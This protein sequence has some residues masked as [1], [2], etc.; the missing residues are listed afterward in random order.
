MIGAV[1]NGMNGHAQTGIGS[2]TAILKKL[3]AIHVKDTAI[4]RLILGLLGTF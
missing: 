1:T 4:F 2:A 3:F